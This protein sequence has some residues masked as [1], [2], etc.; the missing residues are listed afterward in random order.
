MR[1]MVMVIPVRE[2]V[3]TTIPTTAVAVPR[4]MAVLAELYMIR[5]ILSKFSLVSL[6]NMDSTNAVTMPPQNA[7]KVGV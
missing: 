1:A 5:T 3:P 2:N 7:E 6:R 4:V